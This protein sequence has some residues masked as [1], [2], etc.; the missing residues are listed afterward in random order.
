[1]SS[2]AAP[3][4]SLFLA[5]LS[6]SQTV[7]RSVESPPPASKAKGSESQTGS[8]ELRTVCVVN[9]C[10]PTLH[11]TNGSDMLLRPMIEKSAFRRALAECM[12]ATSRPKTGRRSR[13]RTLSVPEGSLPLASIA[14]V[15]ARSWRQKRS[16]ARWEQALSPSQAS[17]GP[18]QCATS[19]RQKLHAS[20]NSRRCSGG[21]SPRRSY[22]SSR[23][24]SR[25]SVRS[26][27]SS[28]TS[29]LCLWK[30]RMRSLTCSASAVAFCNRASCLSAHATESTNSMRMPAATRPHAATANNAA[31]ASL[32]SQ[33]SKVMSSR[34]FPRQAMRI[35]CV[36]ESSV[37]LQRP[38]R[39]SRGKMSASVDVLLQPTPLSP[40]RNHVQLRLWSFSVSSEAAPG[41]ALPF[42]SSS[43]LAMFV[44]SKFR[45]QWSR[46]LS[47]SIVSPIASPQASSSSSST[48]RNSSLCGVGVQ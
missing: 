37:V 22:S 1:M 33:A 47:R 24:S 16:R 42:I 27:Q 26:C 41:F 2:D 43:A 13:S 46:R 7:R 3:R 36:L 30:S 39:T 5:S 23:C 14:S 8:S 31:K 38:S 11:S 48:T 19:S 6:S 12:R 29:W 25:G 40:K 28:V 21:A 44:P 34:H 20:R 10:S 17:T 9:S 45:S 15:C 18:T 35:T 32:A 4:Q